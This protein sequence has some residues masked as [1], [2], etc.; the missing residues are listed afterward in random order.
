MTLWDWLAIAVTAA[1]ILE[2]VIKGAVRL[3]FGLMGVLLG[4]LYAGRLAPLLAEALGAL[5]DN[6]RGPIAALAGFFLILAVFVLVGILLGKLLDKS[7][8]AI[9][10]RVLG[11]FL[12]LAVAAYLAGGFQGLAR[13]HSERLSNSLASSPFFS[14]LS[15]GAVF[16]ELL[17]P[18]DLPQ[19][20]LPAPVPAPHAPAPP[21]EHA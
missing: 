8:L 16:L 11:A 20:V 18:E 13:N 10:N 21:T 4:F 17:I 6:L 19:R 9:L 14:L 1:L 5:P 15:E 7:G 12:G 3:A 2:G